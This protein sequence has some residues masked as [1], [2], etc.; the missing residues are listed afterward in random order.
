VDVPTKRRKAKK[1]H[2]IHA[3]IAGERHA[4]GAL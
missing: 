1:K 2:E 4:I 3:R